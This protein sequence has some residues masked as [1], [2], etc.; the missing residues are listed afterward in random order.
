M[1]SSAHRNSGVPTLIAASASLSLS[2]LEQF[3]P[4]TA[5]DP[6]LLEAPGWYSNSNPGDPHHA[7]LSPQDEHFSINFGPGLPSHS[8]PVSYEVMHR[9]FSP[10][11][12]S[13]FTSPL[14]PS[15]EHFYFLFPVISYLHDGTALS[16]SPNRL[17]NA[18]W[19]PC[20]IFP[21]STCMTCRHLASLHAI[22]RDS[23]QLTCKGSL[24]SPISRRQQAPTT[25]P[26]VLSFLFIH[27]WPSPHEQRPALPA[28]VSR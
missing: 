11:R 10:L 7:P 27:R 8:V 16:S 1:S 24:C 19:P 5:M 15:Q 4:V 22:T 14:L 26:I 2:G 17:S 28:H 18:P 23:P 13:P 9:R 20:A 21:G 6:N 3:H 12:H 25:L